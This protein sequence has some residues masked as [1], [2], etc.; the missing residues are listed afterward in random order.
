M[1]ELIT[2]KGLPVVKGRAAYALVKKITQ[3]LS[4][5]VWKWRSN[6]LYI[7][8]GVSNT[9]TAILQMHANMITTIFLTPCVIYISTVAGFDLVAEKNMHTC[10]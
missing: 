7:T 5:T 10:S 6:Q 8:R 4:G 2:Y 1:I 3:Y 9:C